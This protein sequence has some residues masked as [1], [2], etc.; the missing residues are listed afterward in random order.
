M[1]F[2]GVG[3]DWF[4]EVRMLRSTKLCRWCNS[5]EHSFPVSRW[6]GFESHLA[7]NF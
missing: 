1:R 5:V 6:C 2:A 4:R 3:G 7:L